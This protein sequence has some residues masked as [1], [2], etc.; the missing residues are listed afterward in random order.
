MIIS[1][2]R[3]L[4]SASSNL[5]GTDRGTGRPSF[6]LGFAPGGVCLAACVATDAGALLPHRF[7]L[8]PHAEG[9]SASLLHFAVGSPRLAVSQHRALWS[10]DFPHLAAP[11]GARRDHPAC[12]GL[13]PIIPSPLAGSR[14]S[15]NKKTPPPSIPPPAKLEEGRSAKRRSPSPS[16][17]RGRD[18]GIGAFPCLPDN[19]A[20][21]RRGSITSSPPMYGRS[22]SGTTTLPSACW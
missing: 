14:V 7:T 12:L 16:K 3:Q 10:A 4:P 6:L 5:P 19:P 2:G 20:I 1:L 22:T 13:A 15:V 18:R 21:Q 17:A 8:T 9:H 11:K